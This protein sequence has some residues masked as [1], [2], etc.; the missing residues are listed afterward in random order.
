MR[1]SLG[2][3]ACAAIIISGACVDAFAK[4]PPLVS[5][6]MEHFRDTATIADDAQNGRVV[7]STEKGYVQHSGPLHMVWHDEFLTATIDKKTGEKSFQ[8]REEITYN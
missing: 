2:A 3:A 5:L 4:D 6:N 8:V 7:I 1:A